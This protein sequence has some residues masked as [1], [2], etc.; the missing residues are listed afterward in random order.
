MA[1]I[2]RSETLQ[3]LTTFIRSQ[4]RKGVVPYLLI[5]SIAFACSREACQQQFCSTGPCTTVQYSTVRTVQYNTEVQYTGAESK[6]AGSP[7]WIHKAR[8]SASSIVFHFPSG[9]FRIM[10]AVWTSEELVERSGGWTCGLAI[11]WNCWFRVRSTRRRKFVWELVSVCRCMFAL[12]VGLTE[13]SNDRYVRKCLLL[14]YHPCF[15]VGRQVYQPTP[16]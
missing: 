7:P 5:I 10:V 4:I 16:F 13:T 12:H 14:Q 8:E 2:S 11:V 15:K 9:W 1:L 3:S 6:V